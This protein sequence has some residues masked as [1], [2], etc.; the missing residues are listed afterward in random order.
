MSV[1]GGENPRKVQNIVRPQIRRFRNLYYKLLSELGSVR[2]KDSVAAEKLE[3]TKSPEES[4]WLRMGL[5]AED[6]SGVIVVRPVLSRRTHAD[7]G[8]ADGDPSQQTNTPEHRAGMLKKLPRNLKKALERRYSSKLKMT[9]AHAG[10]D[11]D[12]HAKRL[13]EDEFWIVVARQ[14]SLKKVIDEGGHLRA[15]FTLFGPGTKDAY[16]SHRNPPDHPLSRNNT[17]SQG[18]RDR[19]AQEE[20]SICESKGPQVVE[21]EDGN[22]VA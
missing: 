3:M 11:A 15:L 2:A 7:D 20:H 5:A 21:F 8:Q 9:Y 18:L 16:L 6:G 12:P 19:W 10:E 14:D 17:D 13:S 22:G 1:P 4:L